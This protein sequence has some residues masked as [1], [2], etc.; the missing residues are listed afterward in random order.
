MKMV[1]TVLFVLFATLFCSIHLHAQNSLFDTKDLSNVKIDNYSDDELMSFY[2]RAIGSGISE[3]QLY[4][5]AADR[6]LP[7][8]EITKLRNRLQFLISANK[9]TLKSGSEETKA[10]VPHPYDTIG[11]NIPLQKFKNDSTIFGSE[12]FTTNSLVFEPNLRIPAPVGYVL[13]PDDEV[14]VSVYGYSEKKYDLTINEEGEI[15]IPNVG[16]IYLSGLSIEEAS[17][18]IKSKL[19]S[20]IYR[21]ISTGRTKVQISLGKIRSQRW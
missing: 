9:Q 3:S 20:T 18:K 17:E 21:A 13:G 1:K 4:T 8:S 6:G 2:N 10:E 19:A 7:D 14:V 12:L 11:Q 5:M 15:F 16:P